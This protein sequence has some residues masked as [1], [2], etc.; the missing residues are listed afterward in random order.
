MTMARN[1]HSDHENLIVIQ[2][3]VRPEDI[4]KVEPRPYPCTMEQ[5]QTLLRQVDFEVNGLRKDH[6]IA[7]LLGR[8]HGATGRAA[9]VTNGGRKDMIK[10]LKELLEH[11]VVDQLDERSNGH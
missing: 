1:N 2:S 10:V 11:L 9:F 6:F 3:L 5:L 7:V 4:G 8:F